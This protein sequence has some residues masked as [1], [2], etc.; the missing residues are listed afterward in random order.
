MPPLRATDFR[1][2][3]GSSRRY[4]HITTGETLS[5]RQF[6][7]LFR[8]P[9]QGYRSFEEKAA[10][11]HAPRPATLT[12][13]MPSSAAWL[14]ANARSRVPHGPSTSRRRRSIV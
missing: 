2:L 1:P 14:G 7:Q 13:S 10:A 6:D 4:L 5:R 9:A 8:L 11:R 12:A 3:G